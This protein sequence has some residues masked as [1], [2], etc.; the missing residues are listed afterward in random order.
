MKIAQR[1]I[2]GAGSWHRPKPAL[3]AYFLRSSSCLIGKLFA[4]LWMQLGKKRLLERCGFHKRSGVWV[5]AVM[6]ALAWLVLYNSTQLHQTLDCVS[7][8]VFG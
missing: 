1:R 5:D 2:V 4:T 6:Y 3:T 8:M 7:P